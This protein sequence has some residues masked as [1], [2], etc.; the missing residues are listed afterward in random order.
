MPYTKINLRFI[1]DL[2]QKLKLKASRRKQ[3]EYAQDLQ[4]SK[5]FINGTQKYT[6]I[7]GK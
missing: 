7:K 1:I 6:N 4:V 2:I 3:G 5:A